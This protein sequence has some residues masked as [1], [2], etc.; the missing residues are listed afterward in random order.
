[1]LGT[2]ACRKAVSP[3][4]DSQDARVLQTAG[5]PGRNSTISS[6]SHPEV[7]HQRSDQRHRIILSTVSL[8]FQGGLV[9]ISLR[10]VLGIVVAY[11][12]A[13]IWSS[14]IHFSTWRGAHLCKI[15]Q[16]AGLRILSIA[17]GTELKVS[18]YA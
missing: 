14:V 5:A 15:A 13:I 17:L 7:G 3:P 12:T 9:P 4:T 18:D 2:D 11:V 1:M 16:R 10:P 8:Q 6:D